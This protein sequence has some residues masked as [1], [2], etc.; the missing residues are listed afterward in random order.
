VAPGDGKSTAAPKT[1]CIPPTLSFQMSMELEIPTPPKSLFPASE[2]R[3]RWDD[4]LTRWLSQAVERVNQGAVTPTFDLA[5]FRSEL[6]GFDFTA[7]RSLDELLPW[8][9]AQMEHG[10]VHIAHPRYFGLYN[11]PATFPAQCADRIAA[12]FNPQLATWTTSPAAV[13]I[14]RH[15]IKAVASRAGL[16]QEAIGHFTSGGSEANYTALL[17][18]LT[19][20]NPRFATEGARAFDGPP[21]FYVS[22]ECH[23]AWIKIALQAGIGR[24]AARLVETDG[25]G[26]MD[27]RSLRDAIERDRA[28]GCAP[29]MIVAT[30][31][32]TNAGMSDPLEDCAEI[33][34]NYGLW[35][36]VDA[37]WGGAMIASDRLR[38]ALTGIERAD[39]ILIDAHKWF[40]T[41]M[42]CGMFITADASVLADVFQVSTSF[43]PSNL[44]DLDP[45]VTSMQ[46]SRRFMG[47]RL[48]LALAAAGWEGYAVHVERAVELA[49]LIGARLRKR[50]WAIQN[51]SP[52][53]VLC[54][55]PPPQLGTVASIAERVRASG[56]AWVAAAK[57]ER[58]DVIR[59]CVTHGET[60]GTDI[61]ALVEALNEPA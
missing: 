14:E 41:T 46:W 29:T 36:H 35:Y 1:D 8:T 20:T 31:G 28:S 43:M 55:V 40:A 33:A 25:T 56:R 59:I 21:T 9:I 22:R 3:T 54:A 13:E 58:R 2:E 48:F 5:R 50:G 15:V 61:A 16:P 38:G 51:Q 53:G 39:S 52:F 7:P 45:Y 12:S 47:L 18:A 11:P 19:R 34:R 17:C 37:A 24:L 27:L 10:L 23:L 32:T 30:A 49:G 57:F 4:I 44:Q 6:A 60:N 26:C 42:G